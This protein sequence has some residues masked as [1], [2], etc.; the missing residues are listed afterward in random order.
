MD[1]KVWGRSQG[2][3]PAQRVFLG[4]SAHFPS[5]SSTV[6]PGTSTPGLKGC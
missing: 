1:E 5:F 6:S 3:S 4:C 2:E